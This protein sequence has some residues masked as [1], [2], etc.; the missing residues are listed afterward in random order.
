LEIERSFAPDDWKQFAREIRFSRA[1][2]FFYYAENPATGLADPPNR[3]PARPEPRSRHVGLNYRFSQWTHD[4]M[5]SPGKLLT[6]L[7][8]R[9]CKNSA[10]PT[11]GPQLMRAIEHVSKSLLF[12]CKDC[13]D[14]SLPEIAFLCPESQC[15]KNQRNGPCGGTQAGRCEVE[16]YGDCIW[17]RAYERLKADGNEEALLAHV[18]VLQDQGLRGTSAW[19]NN[20]L[21]RHHAAK[22]TAPETQTAEDSQSSLTTLKEQNPHSASTE[23]FPLKAS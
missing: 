21:G 9:L 14:C 4:V 12:Q 10:D 22:R 2:E 7:G 3:E 8:T 6:N 20:W 17:L 11:Q 5:F 23:S 13:G 1:N 18:P 19:A 16:G 15:A